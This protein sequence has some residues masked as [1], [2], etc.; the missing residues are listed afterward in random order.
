MDAQRFLKVFPEHDSSDP[1]R[2]TISYTAGDEIAGAVVRIPRLLSPEDEES[3]RWYIE[4]YRKF[5]FEPGR[6][7]AANTSVRLRQ[8]GEQLF[9]CMFF[10][11][12]EARDLWMLVEEKLEAT[13]FQ[14]ALGRSPLMVPWELLWNPLDVAPVSCR[15]ASFVRIGEAPAAPKFTDITGAI[16]ILLVIS[17]PAGILDAP[18]RSVATRLLERIAGAPK[19]R[20]EVLRPPTFEAFE[21]ALRAA[22]EQGRPYTMVHFDG[23]GVYEDFVARSE[24]RPPRRRRGYL[25]FEMSGNRDE[26]DHINAIELGAALTAGGNPILILNACRSA[27]AEIR[28]E[29]TGNRPPL[30]SLADEL[31]RL[32]QPAVLA[33][34]YN[35]DVET[36]S[37]FVADLYEE[38]V[39]GRPLA[40][41]VQD[42]RRK[43]FSDADRGSRDGRS[44]VHDWL[45]PVLFE[46]TPVSLPR[47]GSS[48]GGVRSAEAARAIVGADDTLMA[49]ERAFQTERV[50]VLTGPVG[51][52]KTTL[53]AEYAVWEARTRDQT[54]RQLHILDAA[55]ESSTSDPT[56]FETKLRQL[57]A[58]GF[59]VLIESRA[60]NPSLAPKHKLVE[61]RSLDFPD[62]ITLIQQRLHK[63][64][65]FE[66]E[67]WRPVLDFT[68]GNP[69]VVLDI[70]EMI[71]ANPEA[72]PSVILELARSRPV[73]LDPG[74]IGN[75]LSALA[76]EDADCVAMATLFEGAVSSRG[77]RML[78]S[79][80]SAAHPAED[81][82]AAFGKLCEA[83]LATPLGSSYFQMHPGLP[84]LLLTEFEHRHPDERGK[85]IRAAAVTLLASVCAVFCRHGDCGEPNAHEIQARTLGLIEPTIRRVLEHAIATAKWREAHSLSAAL[86]QLLTEQGRR[87][88][89]QRLADSLKESVADGPTGA[90]HSGI[91]GLRHLLRE[92]HI[93]QL[94]RLHSLAEAAWLQER[95]LQ[96]VR[97][98]HAGME[99]P[100]VHE[101]EKQVVIPQLRRMGNI[102]R[103]QHDPGAIRYCLEAL[104]IAQKL[105]STVEEQ[106]IA[107]QLATLHLSM[108]TVDW[109]ELGYWVTYAGELCADDDRLGRAR[110][111]TLRGEMA[112]KNSQAG[113]AVEELR[114]ALGLLPPD[115]SDD[116]AE[117]EMQLAHA[118]FQQYRNVSDSMQHIQSAIAWFDRDQNVY[119]AAR[120]RLLAARI[121]TESEESQRAFFYAIE[122]SRAFASLAPHA[123]PEALE[124]HRL[125]TAVDTRKGRRE[126]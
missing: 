23:H 9:N 18:F 43:L 110:L 83:G 13:K 29:Q 81:A 22:A 82:N 85:R 98:E 24:G 100:A 52:G 28:I 48:P 71:A 51:S 74:A 103:E 60:P 50:V 5:P 62:R 120:A 4:E 49:L 69:R 125:A 102:F 15:A 25:V 26:P 109:D 106:R 16:R 63:S 19:V 95:L 80:G 108:D 92:D 53:A 10:S 36:A 94:I 31:L 34:Q 124:A 8:L 66:S 123:E 68:Q 33:M 105:G 76:P 20:I 40:E 38:L 37:R 118:L 73:G 107:S 55:A 39:D 122:A 70:A 35:V 116:R 7:I 84:G 12:Q 1:G 65:V 42:G 78:A 121:M 64:T 86:R 59:F 117:C 97:H 44:V 77:L 119:H 58:D 96:Q 3:I 126:P 45:V 27:R 11:S 104:Q 75:V 56:V 67:A 47:G 99:G 14:F 30:G 115:P 89:W 46:V 88:E 6:T 32:G 72:Q 17:R 41:A 57:I 111:A 113:L 114:R 87:L 91:E 54:A 112:L 21:R 90:P 61:A 79:A 101:F 2:V 93:E